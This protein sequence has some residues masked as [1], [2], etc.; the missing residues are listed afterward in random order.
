MAKPFHGARL[1]R[2]NHLPLRIGIGQRSFGAVENIDQHLAFSKLFPSTDKEKLHKPRWQRYARLSKVKGVFEPMSSRSSPHRRSRTARDLDFGDEPSDKKKTGSKGGSYEGFHSSPVP[3]FA[4]VPVAPYRTHSATHSD[5]TSPAAVVVVTVKWFNAEKGFGFVTGADGTDVFIHGAVARQAG[6]LDLQPGM[7]LKVELGQA[8][9][10]TKVTT[11]HSVE[12]ASALSG[13]QVALS[14]CQPKPSE[15][16]GAYSATPV[17]TVKGIVKWYNPEKG[18]GFMV[19]ENGRDVFI[20]A[21]AL[22]RSQ[23]TLLPDGCSVE[24]GVVVGRSGKTEVF[25]L[26]LS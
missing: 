24:A 15:P 6:V 23:V 25:S 18:F 17:E 20:H 1:W 4:V 11:V 14:S 5:T 3:A 26:R 13:G 9:R 16:R 8:D 7:R 10:G 12:P 19:G 21:S 2:Q 22:T